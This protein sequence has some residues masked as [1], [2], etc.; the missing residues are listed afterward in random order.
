[1][2]ARK[3]VLNLSL[4][5][6]GIIVALALAEGLLR[7]IGFSNSFHYQIDPFIWARFKPNLD[8]IYTNEGHG[9]VQTNSAGY[10][11]IE[12][13]VE[14]R[15]NV[16]RIAVLGDSYTEASQVNREEAFPAI[17]EN[18]L[19]KC[20]AFGKDIEAEILNFGI[21]GFG[22][23][24]ELL[25]FRH[26]VVNYHPDM[27]ILAFLTG[28]DIRN[29]SKVLEPEKLQPFFL[30]NKQAELVEDRSF[31][32]APRIRFKM[33]M[34]QNPLFSHWS[35]IRLVQLFARVKTN[36]AYIVEEMKSKQDSQSA[37]AEMGL[38][39]AIYK[40]APDAD[41]ENAWRITER[42]LVQMGKEVTSS[43][44]KLSVVTLS[45]GIQ[46]TPNEQATTNY[47][48]RNGFKDIF[49]PDKKIANILNK[50]G[51]SMITLAPKLQAIAHKSGQYMHGFDK[52]IGGGHWN[53]NGHR[54][55]AELISD[56]LCK[57]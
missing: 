50:H 43:G 21:S 55:A 5:M 7:L 40:E 34:N 37:S 48:Y 36:V 4:V 45:N 19:N 1:M 41:W 9:H 31:L 10:R 26:E 23:G 39:D 32:N 8:Y 46:V 33:Y 18:R 28:N 27:V 11:D 47:M 13:S 30:L 22:T 38:D 17:L 56:Q 12:R 53:Q 16:F 3:I 25:M 52:N 14:K 6:L 51:I 29:N 15:H 42:L 2:T 20:N 57:R 44:A 54:Y 49:L 24:N 35:D